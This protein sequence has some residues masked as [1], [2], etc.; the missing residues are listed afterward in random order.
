MDS[1]L[2][3][4]ES[5]AQATIRAMWDEFSTRYAAVHEH[6]TAQVWPILFYH[7]SATQSARAKHIEVGCGSE[8]EHF[9]SSLN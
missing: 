8:W 3:F 7:C 9:C 1:S 4:D 6:F 5:E 2:S